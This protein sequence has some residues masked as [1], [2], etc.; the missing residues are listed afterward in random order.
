[1]AR[2]RPGQKWSDRA[3]I[4]CSL[5][6]AN[7]I[8]STGLK[9]GYG[10]K[11]HYERYIVHFRLLV[12]AYS[13]HTGFSAIENPLRRVH[14]PLIE[15]KIS[16]WDHDHRQVG[17]SETGLARW[18]ETGWLTSRLEKI[19]RDPRV[20]VTGWQATIAKLFIDTRSMFVQ[21]I[22]VDTKHPRLDGDIG[23]S[24]L[25]KENRKSRRSQASTI[26]PSYWALISS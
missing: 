2:G 24:W 8:L 13:V 1:M 19:K 18:F 26:I 3:I 7:P 5:L 6:G 10:F 12:S 22:P 17:Y 23:G 21:S 4:L 15:L 14:K 9:F 25:V 20:E 16:L 11:L